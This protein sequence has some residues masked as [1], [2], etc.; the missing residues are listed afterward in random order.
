LLLRAVL[1]DRFGIDA[2]SLELRDKIIVLNL[3]FAMQPGR[4]LD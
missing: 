4:E 3:A 2:P 1:C